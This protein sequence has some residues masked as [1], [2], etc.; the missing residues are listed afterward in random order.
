MVELKRKKEKETP[1]E[2]K[3]TSTKKKENPQRKF[4]K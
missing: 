1:Q 2:A 3:P 4:R